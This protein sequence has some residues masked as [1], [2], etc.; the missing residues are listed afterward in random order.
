[1]KRKVEILMVIC[2]FASSFLLARA[3]AALT[4]AK[5]ASSNKPCIVLDAGHGGSD[6]GKVTDDDIKEK[7][8]NLAVVKKLKTLFENKGFRVVLTRKSDKV[9]AS[10]DS[11]N[12][13]VEDMRNRVALITKTN[14]VMTVSIHQNSFPDSSVSGPQVFFFDQSPEGEEIA[15]TIQESL[16]T[17]LNPP[18][19]RVSKSNDNYYILKKTPTPIVIVE[20]GFLS[21]EDEK[22]QLTT[23]AYQQKLARAIYNGVCQYLNSVNNPDSS[24]SENPPDSSVPENFPTETDSGSTETSDFDSNS[25]ST[26]E[27]YSAIDSCSDANSGSMLSLI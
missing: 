12:V 23:D 10:D 9:M 14:P 7:D 22:N 21:N 25:A 13:K 16:N 6:P 11:D 19:P 1:M 2:L 4:S 3:G 18:K 15:A 17:T 20:C 5:N 26:A 27:P 8:L 24:D